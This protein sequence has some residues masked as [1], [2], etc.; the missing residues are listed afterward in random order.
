M[1]ILLGTTILVLSMIGMDSILESYWPTGPTEII[2]A[3]LC[4]LLYSI[5]LAKWYNAIENAEL[6]YQKNILHEER[7]P[8][9][10]AKPIDWNEYRDI[11][12]LDINSPV[13]FDRNKIYY[14]PKK[15]L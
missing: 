12:K 4:I 11:P 1:K 14:E 10:G 2:S 6:S 7:I 15:P 13:I 3:I 8:V 9:I 5:Y